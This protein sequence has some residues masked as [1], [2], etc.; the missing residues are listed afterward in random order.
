MFR[1]IFCLLLVAVLFFCGCYS[2]RIADAYNFNVTRAEL[3]AAGVLEIEGNYLEKSWGISQLRGKVAGDAVVLSGVIEHGKNNIIRHSIARIPAYI[4]QVKIGSKVIWTR[5]AK[6]TPSPQPAPVIEKIQALKIGKK[7]MDF[8]LVDFPEFTEIFWGAAS[9]GPKDEIQNV[10]L[11]SFDPE[12]VNDLSDAEIVEIVG[13]ENLRSVDLSSLKLP[14]LKRLVLYN[15]EVFGLEKAQIPNLQE[16]RID[17]FRGVPLSKVALPEK[18]PELRVVSIQAFAG[19][20]DFNSLAGKALVKLQI[21]G[22]CSD[23]SFLKGMPLEE[24]KLSG[25]RVIYGQFEILKTLPLKKL[26]LASRR[27]EKWDFLKGMKLEL[28]DI[29]VA[30]ANDFSPAL[31][32]NMPLEVLR[33]Y[34][35]RRDFGDAW[36]SCRKLPLKELILRGGVVPEK[37]LR[38]S[39]IERLALVNNFWYTLDPQEIFIRMSELKQLAM[40]NGVVLRNNRPHARL[41]DIVRW[42]RLSGNKLEALRVAAND[43]YFMKN[44]PAVTRLALQNKTKFSLENLANRTFECLLFN[45]DEKELLR[46]RIINRSPDKTLPHFDY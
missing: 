4:N 24:L 19:N 43:L 9:D 39:L 40:W 28:L 16:F 31:L 18:L 10:F 27:I 26:K 8:S 7:G 17:D 6:G 29:E 13:N 15:V 11:D 33:I 32:E 36:Q 21:H 12:V 2:P 34:T 1:G 45:Y 35:N 37:F 20:F 25:F 41:D 3:T 5:N 14:R 46:H 38:K 44:L 42:N 30:G 23:F 22:D